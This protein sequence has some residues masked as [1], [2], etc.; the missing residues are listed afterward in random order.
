VRTYAEFRVDERFA[1]L[2][3]RDDE[4]KRLGDSV[5][6]IE[7][8]T[9]DARYTRV[10]ELQAQLLRAEGKPFFY[11]WALRRRY[12]TSELAAAPRLQLVVATVFEPAGEEC[13]TRYDESLACTQ[14]GAGARQIGPLVLPVRRIPRNKDFAKTIGGELVV[15][16]R[17]RDLFDD[18]AISGVEL[19]PVRTT[20]GQASESWYQF[21]TLAHDAIVVPPT[22]VGDEPFHDDPRGFNRCRR[23]DL[24]GLN[25]LSEV[26]IRA[27]S[28]GTTDVVASRQF[29]GT[30]RGLLRPQRVTMVSPKV[31]RL[32]ID[33]N[34]TGCDVEVV[35]LV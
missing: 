30:R 31:W 20:S 35:H 14:C 25:L 9:D 33:N 15:S 11:G 3:F 10:G 28:N 34:L 18:D 2:L 19:K 13:G 1:A 24:L 4:G 26:S 22:V 12:A 29:I 6:K 7:L 21:V 23:E 32:L 27:S 16:R 8:A 5:R 17:V